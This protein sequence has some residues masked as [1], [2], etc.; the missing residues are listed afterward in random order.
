M[1]FINLIL[2][3]LK[4][5]K[6]QLENKSPLKKA[7]FLKWSFNLDKNKFTALKSESLEYFKNQ[8]TYPKF[9]F[10]TKENLINLALGNS[11]IFS[12][13]L[14][15]ENIL[16][17]DYNLCGNISFEGEINFYLP[18]LFIKLDQNLIEI[19]LY[20]TQKE[21]ISIKNFLLSEISFLGRGFSDNLKLSLKIYENLELNKKEKEKFIKNVNLAL[22]KINSLELQKVVLSSKLYYKVDDNFDR[23][24]FFKRASNLNKNTYHF[25][26]ERK[27]DDAFLGMSPETLFKIDKLTLKTEALAGTILPGKEEFLLKDSKNLYE[28]SLVLKDIKDKL[29]HFSQDI[30][31]EDVSIRRLGYVSH[32]VQLISVLLKKDI[33]I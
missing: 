4:N 8:K 30:S 29:E 13:P 9:Y 2:T 7:S 31:I 17:I 12:S 20:F 14:D 24:K 33:K 1:S 11:Y 6:D 16:D 23:Y 3:G 5:F 21:I 32:L 18:K 22:G 15:L 25:I 19:Y 10:E 26:L 27:K 28:N